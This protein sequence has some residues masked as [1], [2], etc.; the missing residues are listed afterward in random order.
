MQTI[1]QTHYFIT[2]D[3]R[4]DLGRGDR[5][6]APDPLCFSGAA[7]LHRAGH[8]LHQQSRARREDHIRSATRPEADALLF[9]DRS[10]RRQEPV[11]ELVRRAR[12]GPESAQGSFVSHAHRRIRR[13]KKFP[14][15]AQSRDHPG[16]LRH[17]AA[18]VSR[19]AGQSIAMGDMCR[20]RKCSGN[21][22]S[23]ISPRFTQKSH[24]HPNSGSLS[25]TIGSRVAAFS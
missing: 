3:M 16:R 6:H 10:L 21:I 23:Q 13:R 14:A 12:A 24:R 1:L 4:A 20:T 7:R 8:D 9:Q 2:K 18:L 15:R 5:W 25:A 22:V 17:P 11:L 19:K